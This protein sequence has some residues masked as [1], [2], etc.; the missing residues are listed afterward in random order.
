MPGIARL[1]GAVTGWRTSDGELFVWG[2]RRWQLMRVYNL[3]EGL[4]AADDALPRR[5]HEEPVDA[6]RHAGVLLDEDAFAAAL[7]L[8]YRL[9]GWDDDGVPTRETL[10]A[11]DLAW[12]EVHLTRP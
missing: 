10:L 8:Y 9:T 5:F 6:G 3:R 4:S 2:R 7:R 11:L 12:A 1:V